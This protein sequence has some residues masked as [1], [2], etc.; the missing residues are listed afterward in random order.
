M[1]RLS[2]S[3]QPRA[4]SWKEQDMA[5]RQTYHCSFC[6]KTHDQVKRLIAGP[7]GVYICD[8]CI[9]LCNEIL[10][11]DVPPTVAGE[12]TAHHA[13]KRGSWTAWW[14]RLIPSY[15]NA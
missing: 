15:R 10:A 9:A 14:R 8:Q 2:S 13:A 4:T 7:N 3:G 12:G 5:R 11:H 1:L 6:G